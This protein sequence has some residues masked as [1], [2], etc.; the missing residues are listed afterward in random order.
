MERATGIELLAQPKI[1]ATWLRPL[2]RQDWVVYL[3]RPSVA[4]NMC[5]T[6]SAATLIVWPSPT[7]AWSP[8]PTAKSLFA[9]VILLT[10]TNRSCCL[11][12][13]MSSC[14]ASYCTSFQKASCASVTSAFWPTANAPHSYRFAF[15]FWNRHN[16]RKPNNT[17]PAPKTSP[18]LGAALSAVDR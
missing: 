3:K 18:I 7:I 2:F 12:L 14:V 4:P 5:C 17:V 15:S 8:S 13:L 11:Y 6:I 10:I 16:N 9:G 1:F